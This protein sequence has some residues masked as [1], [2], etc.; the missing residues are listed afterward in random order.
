MR[1]LRTKDPDPRFRSDHPPAGLS[2]A[3]ISFLAKL[4][5][6]YST[7]PA[8]QERFPNFDQILKAYRGSSPSTK[9]LIRHTVFR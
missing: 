5:P 1:Y 8:A 7:D 3:T 2:E 4:I 6:V 9:K